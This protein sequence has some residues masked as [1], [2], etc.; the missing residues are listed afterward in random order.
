M[1][2]EQD[3]PSAETPMPEPVP[4]PTSKQKRSVQDEF[5]NDLR[6]SQTLAKVLLTCGREL[7]GYLKAFD[8]FTILLQFENADVLIYKSGIAA[9][10]PVGGPAHSPRP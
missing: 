4:E 9:L 7:N 3:F 10:G 5:L 6:G 2:I 8:A 1:A